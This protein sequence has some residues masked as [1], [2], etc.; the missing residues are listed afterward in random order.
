MPFG[1]SISLIFADMGAFDTSVARK[2]KLKSGDADLITAKL[3]DAP[4]GN[5][6]GIP[7][8][9]AKLGAPP[10]ALD[11]SL[12]LPPEFV[13]YA[14][15]NTGVSALRTSSPTLLRHIVYW[16]RIAPLAPF[17]CYRESPRCSVEHPIRPFFRMAAAV[18]RCC[19]A[20]S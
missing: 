3:V 19:L 17:L 15:V 4:N 18:V 20:T 7:A 13:R 16:L 6:G 9:A 14:F 5:G 8:E 2:R 11:S 10:A 1:R 12:I